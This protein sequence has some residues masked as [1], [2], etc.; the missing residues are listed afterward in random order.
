MKDTSQGHEKASHTGDI[1]QIVYLTKDLC[2][3]YT[4]T[5]SDSTIRKQTTNYTNRQKPGAD[6]G[7]GWQLGTRKM[8][9]ILPR[10]GRGLRARGLRRLWGDSDVARLSCDHGDCQLHTW[11]GCILLSTN[12]TSMKGIP[13]GWPGGGVVQFAPSALPVWTLSVDLT[14]PYQAMPWQRPRGHRRNQRTCN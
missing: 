8:L 6:P 11:K 1:W 10:Q 3:K 4:K 7:Q 9:P 13:G 2:P 5:Y 14:L 12:H